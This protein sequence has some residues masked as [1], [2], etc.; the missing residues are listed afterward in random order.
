M[1]HHW[2]A[3]SVSVAPFD[4]Q[5]LAGGQ[6]WE[7]E[8]GSGNSRDRKILTGGKGLRKNAH[9]VWSFRDQMLLNGGT[10]LAHSLLKV[11]SFVTLEETVF[12]TD[13]L[14]ESDIT[15]WSDGEGVCT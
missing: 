14:V 5:D 7:K 10:S 3:F 12:K 11:D 4:Y 2:K 8:G 15:G 1:I 9:R 13:S 6:R